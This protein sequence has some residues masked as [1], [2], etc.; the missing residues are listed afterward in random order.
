MQNNISNNMN[1]GMQSSFLKTQNAGI[2][3][4]TQNNNSAYYAK[5]GEPMYIKEMDA[6]ED[7]IIS[8]DE[9]K[10]YCD[11]K[12]IKYFGGINS[13]YIWFECPNNMYSWDFFD[14]MLN[15]IQVVGTPGAGFGKNGD[16]F[17][18]LTAFGSRE[19]TIEAVKRISKMLDNIG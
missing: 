17:F 2:K 12:G 3:M 18:R 5:K 11:E 9:F 4:N 13:P 6:D 19:N 10:S 16:N 7:G 8:F 15:E 1:I 14:Y